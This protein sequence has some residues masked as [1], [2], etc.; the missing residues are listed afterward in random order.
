MPVPAAFQGRL[1]AVDERLI[2]EGR[3]RMLSAPEELALTKRDRSASPPRIRRDPRLLVE[4]LLTPVEPLASG[5]PK[6]A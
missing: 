6:S 4:L 3:L 1:G 5:T 2:A